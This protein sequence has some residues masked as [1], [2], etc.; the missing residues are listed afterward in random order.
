MRLVLGQLNLL[1]G[2]IA[3]N[4]QKMEEAI[5]QADHHHQAD[6]ILFSE[7][8]LIGY[9]PE[10]LL[11]R[12][13][14][15]QQV[16]TSLEYLDRVLQQCA[17]LSTL[18]F[19]VPW[20]ADGEC[21]NA[22]VI[23]QRGKAPR[24]Y[25]KQRLPNYGVFDEKRYFS[26]GTET[27]LLEVGG[28]CCAVSLCEDLWHPGVA[29]RASAAGAELMLN[30][31]ASP[32]HHQKRGER[33]AVIRQR[34]R[35]SGLAVVYVNQVGG[36]DELVFDGGSMLF[37][38]NGALVAS[39]PE[40]LPALYP[41]T[42]TRG[43][44]GGIGYRLEQASHPALDSEEASYRAM[45]LGLRD[46]VE[47]NHF[48]G[49]IIGLS[50]GIDS[51]LTLAIAVEALGPQRVEA[52]TMPSRYTAAMSLEDA[53]Q[54]AK[55]L[56]V[57]LKTISIEP[58]FQALLSMLATELPPGEGDATEENLQARVRGQILMALSNR[59]GKM[60]LTTGN[61]S[62]MAVGYATLY[63]D[64]VGGYNAIKDLYKTEVYRMALFCNRQREVIPQRVI[65]RPP[66][67][68]LAPDQRDSDS[69]PPYS[70]LDAILR[71]YIEEQGSRATLIDAGF[72]AAVVDQVIRLVD[73]NE[74]K[75]RQSAPGVKLTRLALGR[76][77][78]YPITSGYRHL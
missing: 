11:L 71:L 10:D 3:G 74:Y 14:L 9:P 53:A 50:G 78:R 49:V 34:I 22:A 46:Y 17:T 65:D 15:P 72:E 6:L 31:N 38:P 24:F 16:K 32:F 77:R 75:R 21:Y 29:S 66:S 7:L 33:E 52:V 67:A 19:G 51:A 64:M 18:V 1:V 45:V 41:V 42:V 57:E 58:G 25:Y 8:S 56:G 2:D 59:S 12:K 36:Q 20:W 35:E 5:A 54:E 28:I 69:L 39:A 23:C 4:C 70:T 73:R 60:V 40:F 30:L 43:A 68:E 26:E 37:A 61:K 13:G 62:E 63:G 48:P 47:K 44:E 76:D 55:T 27:V